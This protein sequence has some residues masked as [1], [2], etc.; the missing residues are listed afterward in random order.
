ML[1]GLLPS[2]RAT[3]EWSTLRFPRA[4]VQMA[5]A[6]LRCRACPA[7]RMVNV[8]KPRLLL[9]EEPG[10]RRLSRREALEA[11]GY[12]VSVASDAI[13]ALR[14]AQAQ[15]PA[16]AVVHA[17][18]PFF[19]GFE[20]RHRLRA[21]DPTSTLSVL[22]LGG[23]GHRS[24]AGD[25][26]FD[27]FLDE[28]IDDGAFVHAIDALVREP[29]ATPPAGE[30]RPD[31]AAARSAFLQS[32][33][34]EL[35]TPLTPLVGYLKLL[36]VGKLGE[37]SG[38]Q[39]QVVEAMSHAAERLG[40][41]VDN[42]VDFATLE[43][44]A[45]RIHHASFN[46]SRMVDACVTGLRSKAR[47]KHVRIEVRRPPDVTMVGDERKLRQ[48]LANVLD[49]AIRYSPHGGDVL[50][51]VR[52]DDASMWFDV[53]DQGPGLSEEAKAAI[54]LGKRQ[55]DDRGGSGLGMPV[56]REIALAHG[57]ELRVESPPAQQ[58]EASHSYSGA[59]VSVRVPLAPG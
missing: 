21:L 15:R 14:Q 52:H 54:D 45:Y 33:A 36:R 34:H 11:A 50:L 31:S 4:G 30:H 26:G 40:R 1:A 46:A 5:A 55:P 18:L 44:G 47:G 59:L 56:S 27:G 2:G 28:K 51:D 8:T 29:P 6:I 49:N 7:P 13:E 43:T 19:D 10:D 17:H 9:V 3:V 24:A 58:P 16:L 39:Q 20:L 53:Y 12:P 41:T 25:A 42:L 38:Q 22:L 57:G 32:L 37:L 23:E 48:A 35:A